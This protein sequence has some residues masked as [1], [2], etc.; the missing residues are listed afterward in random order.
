MKA[1]PMKARN[2]KSSGDRQAATK[3]AAASQAGGDLV[4]MPEAIALLKTTRPTFYRWL[5]SGKLRGM[6]VG[7]QWR[8]YKAD[9]E[10]FLQGEGPRI[11]P[12]AGMM[13]LVETLRQR[14]K[15]AGGMA[16]ISE[17]EPADL[18]AAMLLIAL[19]ARMRASDLHI[20][21]QAEGSSG[22]VRVQA[23]LRV[24]GVLHSQAEFDATLLRPLVERWKTMAGC[25]LQETRRPQDGRIILSI[26]GRRMDLRVCIVPACLGE[27]VTARFLDASVIRLDLD[28]I[29]YAPADRARLLRF[30]D[31]PWGLFVSTGPTGSGKSTALYAC[32]NRCVKPGVKVITV[33]DPVEYLLPGVTQIPVNPAFGVTFPAAMRAVLRCDPDVIMCGEVREQDSMQILIQSVLTGHLVM[34]TLHA[35]EAAAA[36][37][38]MMDIGINPF[39][40]ADAVKLVM[41]QRLVR[42]LC[43]RCSRPGQPS[44]AALARAAD[45]ARQ[46][47]LDWNALPR[48]FRQPAGCPEC[49]QTGFRGRM[50]IAETLEVSPAI[51]A[52]LRRGAGVD[53]LRALAV[54][55]GMTTFAADGIRRAAEGLTTLEE[56]LGV[57]GVG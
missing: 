48:S 47:G 22:A 16:S 30:I 9:I 27:A 39:L 50:V 32:L 24:D 28:R 57:V 25:N 34:T 19:G 40:V 29:D 21:P 35:G 52:A 42:K 4:D 31:R 20:E 49:H 10:R 41:S 51:G 46:G 8:F 11:E 12:P 14:L 7:R 56:V 38:R 3:V 53:E 45:L 15:E 1:T 23:R 44:E 2:G 55:E 54:G 36:L 17:S 37:Q 33:E 6:K 13:T 5:R 26:E 43:P 18:Q